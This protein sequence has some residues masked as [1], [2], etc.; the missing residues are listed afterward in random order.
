ME[1][2]DDHFGD[3]TRRAVRAS[4]RCLQD[5]NPTEEAEPDT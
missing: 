5:K 2:A 3:I 1:P 4:V